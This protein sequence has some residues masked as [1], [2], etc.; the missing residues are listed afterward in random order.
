M[1][2]QSMHA[3]AYLA[4]VFALAASLHAAPAAAAEQK[5]SLYER[6]GGIYAIAT[7][8]DEFIDRLLVNDTLNANPAIDEARER[9]PTPGLKYRVT[10]FVAQAAGG[11]QVYTGRSMR[12]SHEHLNITPRQWRAMLAELEAVLY[13]FNVPAAE[14]REVL[15]MMETLREEIV[16]AR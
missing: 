14:Q 3:S 16:T 2:T 8:V 1:S 6:L 12:A 9:V 10:A 11:P 5:P 13:K 4:F 15:E 7:V